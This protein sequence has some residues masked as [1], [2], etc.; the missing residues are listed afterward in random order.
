MHTSST[1]AGSNINNTNEKGI[2][3]FHRK[4]STFLTLGILCYIFALTLF[5]FRN[6]ITASAFLKQLRFSLATIADYLWSTPSVVI[7]IPVFLAILWLYYHVRREEKSGRHLKWLTT[8]FSFTRLSLLC[9]FFIF[10]LFPLR[11][12]QTSFTRSLQSFPDFTL[13][14]FMLTLLI[15]AGTTLCC[16]Y[17]FA[18]LPLKIVLPIEKV[19]HRF[20][21]WKEPFFIVSLLILS[22]VT[23]GII[24]YTV[25]DHIPHVQD[26]IAQLFQ[27]KIFKMGNLYAPLPPHKEFFDYS[28]VINDNKWYSQYPPGHSLLL[29]LGLF[30]GVPWLIGPLLGTLSI[31][32]FFLIVKTAYR[33]QR[34]L[35]LSCS[36]LFFSPFLL[37]M[38]SSFMNHS[39]TMFFILL[40]LYCY[41]RMSSSHS[42][43]Y[44]IF[45]GLS[46]GYAINIRPLT[47]AA[48]STP[49]ICYLLIWAYKKKEINI[50]KLLSFFIAL[51]SM[52]FLLLLYNYLTNGN[53]FLFG[54][55]KSYHTLGFLGSAQIGPP[56][57]LKGGIINTSN[58]LIGLNLYLFEWPLPSLIFVFI[59]FA[60]PVR[61]NRWD[62]LFLIS[63]LTLIV[64]Y[65]FYYYQDLCFGPRFYYSLTP[66]MVI[67]TV[68]G[69]L[70]LPHW[71][72]KKRFDKR[73]TKASLY[74]LLFLCFLYTFS[75]SLPS[76]IKKYS[77]DYWFVTDKIHHAVKSQ[78]ITNAV[79]FID[80][81]H[82]PYITKPNL[83]VYGLGFLFNS[84]DLDDDTIYAL[85]LKD[86]NSELMM[87]FPNRDYYL[88]KFYS[89]V[90]DFKLL[91]LNG[92][93]KDRPIQLNNGNN[94]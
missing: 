49:F 57:T 88:C 69:F 85:D 90:S 14:D 54:Y 61:K 28:N 59:L 50:K 71:L 72:E 73:K 26:S 13:F 62:Y 76:L 45:S 64:S 87:D 30:L 55:Q 16:L 93:E 6:E 40:F 70:E 10:T 84:P 21:K 27:A 18:K 78:G 58:N 48:I 67:L 15:L 94:N 65:F 47:A 34:L 66:L 92:K 29:T 3:I 39:S 2:A 20:F 43:A 74:L 91:K 4:P 23:T 53:P 51:S 41:L 33:D 19:T 31:L 37:F 8:F 46:L 7:T 17:C 60:I 9:L 44:A 11:W 32:I 83:L 1:N 38:S 75:V 56:H 25:L 24:A 82:P 35:Y 89:S 68:R 12:A 5:T 77:N 36:L 22:L 42:C 79:I 81:W 63:S 52:V 80:A 86:R